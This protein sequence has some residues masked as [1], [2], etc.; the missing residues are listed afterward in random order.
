MLRVAID[1]ACRRNGKPDCISAGGVFIR[2]VDKHGNTTLFDLFATSEVNNSTNQRGELYALH[3]ALHAI[4]NYNEEAQIITDSE[5]IFN[6]MTKGWCTKWAKCGWVTASGEPVKNKD[7]WRRIYEVALALDYAEVDITY[8]H[9]K[10]HCIPFGA[11][12]ADRLLSADVTGEKLYK[13]V[14][15]KFDLVAPTKTDVIAKAQKL[16][17]VNNG[18]ELPEDIFKD[19]VVM[20]TVVDAIA[21]T[22]V[23]NIDA[24][25]Y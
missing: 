16:S 25:T 23:S 17:A 12:T 11:V 18:Y 2:R 5:Y 19:F 24:G 7:L 8:Y 21:S 1:G 4:L 13:E 6:A 22:E 10:G 20:N 15:K 9:I 3:D 14:Q